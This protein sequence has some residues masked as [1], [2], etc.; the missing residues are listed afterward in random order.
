VCVGGREAS[1]LCALLAGG[2]LAL[3]VLLTV[4]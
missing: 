1:N 3:S 2:D 4:R